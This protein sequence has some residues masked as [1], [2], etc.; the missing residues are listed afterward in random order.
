MRVIV[1]GAGVAGLTAA[2]WIAGA[3]HD[4]VVLDK[5]R[6]P[7]GRLATR[8]LGG[9]AL[10]DHGAQFFTARTDPFQA[11]VDVW[12]GDGTVRDWCR[13]FDFDD[14]HPRYCA[15]G[16]MRRLAMRLAAGLDVR[17]SVRVT[18]VVP[19]DVGWVVTWP[20]SSHS[21]AGSLEAEVV[22]LTPPVP[23]TAALLAGQLAVPDLSYSPTLSLVVA[24]GGRPAVPAPGGVQLAD[25]P[26]WSWIGDNVAK[27][28][29]PSPS[30][31]LHTRAEVAAARYDDAPDELTAGLLAAASPWLGDAPV[32]D[33]ALHRWRY[34][35][36]ADVHP[37]RYWASPDGGIVL[38]G[39]AFGGPR[40]E[41][42]FLSGRAAAA[43]V[44]GL[45]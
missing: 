28:V 29:S 13:G 43:Y 7:G 21:G 2:G 17:N 31:T 14:G 3:G 42:A 16:G 36:P 11:E 8:D 22:V 32:L 26:I 44:T 45:S 39:D 38:A 25:D 30:V 24:L 40:V 10:A 41:G 27:G 19:S 23:Q 20:A 4:V 33:V 35:T 9:G 1:V 18:A 15:L 34:A 6:W 12:V 5:G 37:A